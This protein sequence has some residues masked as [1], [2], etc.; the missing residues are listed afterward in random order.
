M[1]NCG[2]KRNEYSTGQHMRI[3]NPQ[4][5]PPQGKKMWPDVYFQYTGKSALTV[6][7][8]ITGKTYR[9]TKPGEMK[10]IDYRDASG[11]MAVP[12]L[13]KVRLEGVEV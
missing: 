6:T 11:M 8:K 1:C 13:K 10:V 3:G 5:I 9:F 2:N 7:G 12:V 4:N